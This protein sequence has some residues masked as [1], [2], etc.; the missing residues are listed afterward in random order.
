MVGID[1]GRGREQEKGRGIV[2]SYIKP[3]VERSTTDPEPILTAINIEPKM[4]GE[5]ARY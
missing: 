4:R 1:C 2:F 3:D 5:T